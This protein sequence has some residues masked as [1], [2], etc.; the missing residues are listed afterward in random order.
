MVAWAA[1]CVGA[2]VALK[3]LLPAKADF[4]AAF[5]L[6]RMLAIVVYMG[7]LVFAFL[8]KKR[9]IVVTCHTLTIDEGR[10][11]VFPL[12]GAELGAWNLAHYGTSQGTA[13]HLRN[14]RH[15]YVLG[16]RDH[17]L[18]PATRIGV[19][20]VESVDGYLPASEFEAII[21]LASRPNPADAVG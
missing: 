18:S 4:E 17:R 9:P 5:A 10:G 7:F 14:G 21:A 11:G 13:L 16:G 8:P 20:P 19:G 1:V 6:G 15:R 2:F 3:D 12:A